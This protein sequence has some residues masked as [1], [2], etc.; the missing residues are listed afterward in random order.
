MCGI[1]GIAGSGVHQVNITSVLKGMRHRGPDGEGSYRDE[2]LVLLHSR[3]AIQDLSEASAQPMCSPDGR[4]VLCYNGEVYNHLELR[5]LIP[6]VQFRTI[7]DTETLLHLLIRFGTSVPEKLNGI[8]AFAF[9]DSGQQTLLLAR[10]HF[11]VKPLY[12][13]ISNAGLCFASE[14]KTLL[15][16]REQNTF[17]LNPNALFHC[18]QLQYNLPEETGFKEIQRLG[19]GVTHQYQLADQIKLIATVASKPY[20]STSLET[21]PEKEWEKV[22]DQALMGAVERQLLSEK[23][24]SFFLSGGIDST[25]LVAMAA[26]IKSGPLHTYTI[27]T[28]DAFSKE[29]FAQDF[30]FA[31][32]FAQARGH[33]LQI[34]DARS[35]LMDSLDEMIF[36]LEELQADPA[37]LFVG[38][39]AAHARKQ[40]HEVLIGGTGADDLFSG[41]RRHQA[42][43]YY[44]I[45]ERIPRALIKIAENTARFLPEAAARRSAKFFEMAGLNK[46]ERMLRSFQWIN[47]EAALSLLHPDLRAQL[48][49]NSIQGYFENCLTELATNA[50]DLSKL[51]HLEQRVFLSHNL[52][53][54]DKMGMAHGVEIRVPYLDNALAALVAGIPANLKMNGAHTKYLLRKVAAKYLPQSIINRSKTG[55]GA[56]IRHWLHHD[57]LFREKLNNRLE[58]L[59]ISHPELFDKKEITKLYQQT[60]SKQTDGTYTL[61]ALA[62]TESWLRQ[63]TAS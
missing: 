18:L 14:I 62:S 34:L 40:G 19:A 33:H 12:Y 54:L 7:S 2:R 32:S 13:T 3:L 29:G 57:P 26:K 24:V 5:K 20:P 21:L 8:F 27:R 11:G 25:L 45:T 31:A 28:G 48:T 41:Y 63:F 44:K 39:I 35:D 42:L 59:C 56:P 51:L 61:F 23:E 16:L 37:A 60:L 6:D 38:N 10:D 22:L 1:A 50:D 15:Q 30:N 43:H 55:F 46:T 36:H 53:Y 17:S 4:Y 58:Q 52:N 49:S 9:Y 47:A